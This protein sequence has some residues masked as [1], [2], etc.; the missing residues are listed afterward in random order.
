MS[1]FN[2][3]L[4]SLADCSNCVTLRLDSYKLLSII[5]FYDDKLSSSFI[6]ILLS[7]SLLYKVLY[8]SD[9]LFWSIFMAEATALEW[10]E[11]PSFEWT[12]SCRL[13]A[14]SSLCLFYSIVIFCFALSIEDDNIFSHESA[15]LSESVFNG[16]VS[17]E[18]WCCEYARVLVSPESLLRIFFY[19]RGV[20]LIYLNLG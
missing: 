2:S 16:R 10:T 6:M 7:R 18:C 19:E 1:Y 3:A 12:F 20:S 9:T 14:L 11:S 5:F 15:W 13:S 8:N 4:L 17:R